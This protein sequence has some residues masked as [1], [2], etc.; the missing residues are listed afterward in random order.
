MSRPNPDLNRAAIRRG[1]RPGVAGS[2]TALITAVLL[3][4]CSSSTPPAP[5]VASSPAEPTS[6][7]ATVA[8]TPT[9]SATP[10]TATATPSPSATTARPSA[11]QAPKDTRTAAQRNEPFTVN[12]IPVVSK[13]HPI[14]ASFQRTS[15]TAPY[16]L[17][18]Q[19]QA[20][21]NRLIAAARAKGVRVLVRSGY[22]S[23]A[24]QEQILARK[25]KE[26]GS[27]TLARRYNAAPGRSEHQTG[28]AVDLWD[29]ATWGVGMRNT[30]VGKWLW[31]NA[32]RY[33]FILRYPN[34]KEKI[35][36]YAFEPW[37]YRY[38]GVADAKQFG[39]N[40]N[41]TLEE[42]LGID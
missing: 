32:Y 30:T 7:A 1:A 35:T 20:A 23:Y 5:T 38:I 29:G 31:A 19:T 18:K 12:G 21:L 34:G 2:L 16:G 6:A 28:L 14:N 8:P 15:V 9:L 27:E 11:T 40:S 3:A 25:I 13:K 36:G 41:L 42:Y 33:G 4:G 39:P 26:Y 22:R 10:T 24:L 37:H 17:T